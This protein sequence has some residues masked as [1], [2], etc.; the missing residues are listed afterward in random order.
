[1]KIFEQEVKSLVTSCDGI[2]SVVFLKDGSLATTSFDGYI[3]VWDL[4]N[5]CR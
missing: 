2:S 5:G 3:E 1:M 4:E